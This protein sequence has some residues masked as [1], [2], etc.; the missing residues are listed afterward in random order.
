MD[1]VIKKELNEFDNF[2]DKV[3]E[4]LENDKLHKPANYMSLFDEAFKMSCSFD[5]VSFNSCLVILF[6]F[7]KEKS[8][9]Q[10]K[11]INRLFS[12]WFKRQEAEKK[13]PIEEDLF[14]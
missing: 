3:N 11:T 13:R 12:H 1:W 10:K 7:A 8:D 4:Y 2:L 6:G 5:V 14:L 9:E